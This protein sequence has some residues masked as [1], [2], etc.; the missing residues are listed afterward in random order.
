MTDIL[1][2]SFDDSIN[3]LT[4]YNYLYTNPI[5]SKN[6]YKL[7]VILNDNELSEKYNDYDIII[8][9]ILEKEKL[10]NNVIAY[11]Q[12]GYITLSIYDMNNKNITNTIDTYINTIVPDG[13]KKTNYW[14]KKQGI[15]NF[16]NLCQDY[17]IDIFSKCD[18]CYSK[19][20]KK[21]VKKIMRCHCRCGLIIN[22]DNCKY[23]GKNNVKKCLCNKSYYILHKCKKC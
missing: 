7:I 3:I 17:N 20:C 4:S 21:C 8:E 5:V 19:L 9:K 6:T 10:I 13:N 16:C 22:C 23:Y 14:Y 11:I 18:Q 12:Y 1:N 15:L 2:L